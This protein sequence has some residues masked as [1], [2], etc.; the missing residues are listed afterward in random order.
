MGFYYEIYSRAE[1]KSLDQTSIKKGN[2]RSALFS[3]IL[4][5]LYSAPR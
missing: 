2:F 5:V 1:Y 3:L 4:F